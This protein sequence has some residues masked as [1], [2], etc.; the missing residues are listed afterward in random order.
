MCVVVISPSLS[1][2]FMTTSLSLRIKET[3]SGIISGWGYEGGD[4]PQ[5]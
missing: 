1:V 2:A 4:H 5:F 3:G